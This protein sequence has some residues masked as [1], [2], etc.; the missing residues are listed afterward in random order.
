MNKFTIAGILAITSFLSGCQEEK[1]VM[2]KGNVVGFVKLFSEE[3]SAV[4]DKSGVKITVNEKH[5]ALTNDAGRFELT[6]ME[7]GTYT[8]TFEKDGFGTMKRFNFI[9]AAGNVPALVS[10][11]N[12]GELPDIN[13]LDHSVSV[14]NGIATVTGSISETESYYFIYYFNDKPEVDNINYAVTYGY[15]YCCVTVTG[16]SHHIPIPIGSSPLYMVAYAANPQGNYSY[17]DFENQK[18]VNTAVK[19]L[20]DPVRVR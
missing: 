6:G 20:F 1:I 8:L 10:D 19:K 15:Q 3:G 16:F 17:Y 2:P 5:S 12:L 9:F 7:P 11:V 4:A 13:I 18:T 14:A